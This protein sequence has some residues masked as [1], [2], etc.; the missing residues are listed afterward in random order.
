MQSPMVVE[1][2]REQLAAILDW[3]RHEVPGYQW[4]VALHRRNESG[5][6][7]EVRAERHVLLHRQDREVDD[8]RADRTARRRP[9][10]A[11]RRC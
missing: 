8:A 1:V 6:D 9:P 11:W 4:G 5:A 2:Y 3:H 10:S 7:R